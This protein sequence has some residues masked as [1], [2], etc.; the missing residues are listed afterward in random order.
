MTTIPATAPTRTVPARGERDTSIDLVRAACLVVVVVLHAMM[1]GVTIGPDGVVLAN[2]LE[3]QAWFAPVSWLAQIMPLFFIAGGFSSITQWRRMR[4]RGVSAADY[5]QLR[6]DRLLRPAAAM[7]AVTGAGLAVLAWSGVPAEIIATAGWRVSQPLWFLGVYLGAQALVPLLV[8]LHE[9][10]PLR[11][12]ATLL[13][14]V[15][16]VDA[17]RL[18][19]GAGAIGYLNLAFVWLL[20]QQLGFVLA[21]GSV[22][23][24]P[25][26]ARI[27]M[28]SAALG[29]LIVLVGSGLYSPDMLVNLNPPTLCIVALGVIQLFAFQAARPMLRGWM[30]SPIVAG[31]VAWV[32]ERAMTVYLWHMNVLITLAGLLLLGGV[33]AGLP[34][35]AP[36]TASWWV[37]RPLWLGVVIVAVASAVAWSARFERGG[38]AP[39][40]AGSAL[41]TVVVAAATVAAVAGV[42]V[43]LVAGLNPV[44]VLAV[45][46]VMGVIAHPAWRRLPLLRQSADSHLRFS[47]GASHRG[48][49]QPEPSR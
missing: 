45:A 30:R 24:M 32:G 47:S 14:A 28:A 21:D 3:G 29:V 38:R 16:A 8:R 6:L 5:V 22:E 13:G 42:A 36:L 37:T 15:V 9:S 44:T 1:V 26:L 2:A 31:A 20:V 39:S 48:G 10:A 35:P 7:L 41:R 43:L 40:V 49:A 33:F 19:T 34:L 25:R 17:L 27:A 18:A 12:A 11:T 46:A 23:R 4:A